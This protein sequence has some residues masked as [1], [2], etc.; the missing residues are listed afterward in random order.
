MK[1]NEQQLRKT[2][3]ALHQSGVPASQLAKDA[4]KELGVRPRFVYRALGYRRKM[5]RVDGKSY[6][7]WWREP[8]K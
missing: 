2:I 6:L 3:I 5:V 8:P 1:Q 4:P 7:T